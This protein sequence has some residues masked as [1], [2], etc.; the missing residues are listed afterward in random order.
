MAGFP[1]PLAGKRVVDL[2]LLYP[3]PATAATLATFGARVTKVEPPDGDPTERLF[4]ETYR[5][6]NRGKTILRLD[7]KT[8]EGRSALAKLVATADI[9]VE[10]YRPGVLARLGIGTD[11]LHAIQPRLVILSIS[12]YGATGPY[13]HHPAHDMTVLGVAG[14]FSAPSQLDGAISRPNIRLADALTVNAASLAAFVALAEAERTGEGQVVDTSIFDATA[15]SCLMMALT[16]GHLDAAPEEQSQV[17]ADSALY[18]CRDGRLMAIATLEDHLWREFLRL[19]TPE[20]HPLRHTR[21]ASRGGRDACKHALAALLGDLFASRDRDDWLLIFAAGTAPVTPVWQGE[22][23]L[24]DSQIAARGSI[25]TFQ[26]QGTT[27]RYPSFPAVF[28]GYRDG[29][30]PETRGEATARSVPA[31]RSGTGPR[32]TS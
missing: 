13:K 4:P 15:A 22:E 28:N 20:D 11:W 21:F 6:L 24:H 12:G 7:L 2:S 32:P 16:K 25:A 8:D 14:Y 10:S 31:G 23:I 19:A 3:G 9:L 17:M 30:V 5:M 29:D 27:A 1:Q 18:P 26:D